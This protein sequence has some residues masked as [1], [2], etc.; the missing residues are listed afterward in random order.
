MSDS[1][2][3]ADVRAEIERAMVAGEAELDVFTM[4]RAL[5]RLADGAGTAALL[6]ALWEGGPGAE[7]PVA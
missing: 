7:P 5:R 2:M 4:L 3:P 1:E 6:S